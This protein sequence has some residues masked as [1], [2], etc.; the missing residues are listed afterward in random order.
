MSHSRPLSCQLSR[1]EPSRVEL[2]WIESVSTECVAF[3]DEEE[4]QQAGVCELD[5]GA[6]VSLQKWHLREEAKASR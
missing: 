1:T 3:A 6:T 5:V 4:H 2:S